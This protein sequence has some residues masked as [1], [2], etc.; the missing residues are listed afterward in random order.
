MFTSLE[1]FFALFKLLMCFVFPAPGYIF[2]LLLQ[3][4]ADSIKVVQKS[5]KAY[6]VMPKGSLGNTQ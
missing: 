4:K 3:Y 6:A 5:V 2:L 1:D